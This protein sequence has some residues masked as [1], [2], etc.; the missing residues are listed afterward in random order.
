MCRVRAGDEITYAAIDGLAVDLAVT[1]ESLVAFI[2]GHL[3]GD[4][5]PQG[6]V[7]RAR[8]VELLAPVIPSKI[9]GIGR[10]YR[11]HASEMGGEVPGEPLMFIKPSTSVIGPGDAIRLPWQSEQVD[12]E[13]ELAIVIG[14]MCRDVPRDRA[15]EV[16]FGF[17]CANDVSAR[18]L[19]RA[20]SQWTRAK[21]FDT[22]CPLGPWIDTEF[23]W[24]DA[25]I[26]CSVNGEIR[27]YA[28]TGDVIFGVPDLVAAVTSVMTLL[29]G[30]VI[31]TGTPAGVGPIGQGDTVSVTIQGLGTLTNTVVD[32]G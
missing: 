3:F 10:N 2:D 20:D 17:T 25:T 7:A 5:S 4:W 29:P 11:D 28:N 6:S 30:D 16:I 19:Q 24:T 32:R 26:I 15:A 1:D 31:L 9:V 23:D 21:G 27:Q 13:A 18:D 8:D 12:H 14:R 22:F